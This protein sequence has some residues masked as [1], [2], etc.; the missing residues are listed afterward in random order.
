MAGSKRIGGII[1]EARLRHGMTQV[2]LARR[3]GVDQSTISEVER[4]LRGLGLDLVDALKHIL[5]L[6]ITM[7]D[8]T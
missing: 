6:D 5:S 3:L 1:K 8:N 7:T 2:E 4:G